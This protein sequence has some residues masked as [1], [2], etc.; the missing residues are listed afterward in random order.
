MKPA[1]EATL[2]RIAADLRIRIPSGT[3]Q[4]DGHT[5]SVGGDAENLAL[6]TRRADAVKQW[7]STDGD[8]PADRIRTRGY[9]ETAPVVLN[10]GA[11]GTDDPA[12]RTKNRRVVISAT[13]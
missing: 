8:V 3:V 6:S 2:R 10:A 11:D 1:A 4:I 7:L 12:G 9:G 13:G 5:D